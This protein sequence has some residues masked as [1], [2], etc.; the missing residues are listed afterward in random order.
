MTCIVFLRDQKN[1]FELKFFLFSNNFKFGQIL[2]WKLTILCVVYDKHLIF[3]TKVG[4]KF[5]NDIWKGSST[6]LSDGQG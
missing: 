6:T 2:F 1:D 3:K 4:N 5:D